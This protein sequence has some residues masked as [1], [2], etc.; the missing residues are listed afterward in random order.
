MSNADEFETV[1]ISDEFTSE[2]IACG[3]FNRD[4]FLDIV[5]GPYWYAG[6][7]F[8]ERHRIFEPVMFDPHGYSR[9]TQPCFVHDFNADGWPD[10][11]YVVR[12]PGPGRNYAFQGWGDAAGWEG[13]WYENPAGSCR[14]WR[15]HPVL[16]NI[17]NETMVWADLND[18]GRPEAVYSTREAYGYASCDPARPDQPWTF[19]P[20]ARMSHH[21]L[22]HGVG[23]GDISGNGRMDI[24]SGKGWWEQPDGGPQDRPWPWHASTFA[25]SPAD[26]VVYDVDGDGRN[27]VVTVWNAHRYGLLWYRQEQNESG[28]ITWERHEILPPEPDESPD[29]LRIS[30][31]HALAAGD[32][33]GDGLPD[34]I[35]GK[36]FWAHGPEGDIEA[37]APAVLYW[38]RLRREPGGVRFVPH[39][40][41]EDCGA[42]T[43]V[44]LADLTGDGRPD[45]LT[46]SKK[47]TYVHFNRMAPSIQSSES[48]DGVTASG[49][50]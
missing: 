31:M 37:D 12:P 32:L 8:E 25:E 18:D 49:S 16:H 5:A 40:I 41:H 48:A 36:R 1:Q 26:I 9:T 33:D 2:S 47:G 19:Q 35:A 38:F 34:I 22:E 7:L 13:V 46:S 3:D 6:P 50:P 10:V 20:I 4:G 29:A 23:V 44:T 11:F 27:D 30:Q 15:P 43:Q 45:V 17:A 42:G 24:V 39:R 14:P 28:G 21:G